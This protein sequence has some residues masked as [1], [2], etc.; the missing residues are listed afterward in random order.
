M[1]AVTRDPRLCL[2][3]ATT[4]QE[5]GRL[6]EADHWLKEAARDATGN[7]FLAADASM[8]AG[9]AA[10]RAINQYFHGDAAGIRETVTMAL[11]HESEDSAYWQSALLTTLGA[12]RFVGGSNR[13]AALVLK[14]AVRSSI[15]TGHAL[16]LIP[17]LGWSAVV[18]VERGDADRARRVLQHIDSLFHDQAGLHAY[19]GAAMAHIARGV[20][21]PNAGN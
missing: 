18:H 5:V 15:G 6:D 4:L 17:A 10:C 14:R 13:D 8:A 19:Y 3:K 7:S 1:E 16:A 9:V 21:A 11:D 2:V 20:S 12:A